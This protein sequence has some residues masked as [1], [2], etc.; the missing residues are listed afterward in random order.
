MPKILKLLTVVG[1]RPQFI[2]AKP[3]S[4]AIA[5]HNVGS[6]D[7]PI[8]EEIVHTGQHYDYAMSQAFFDELEIPEPVVNLEVGSGSHAEMTGAMLVR[9]E[10]QIQ[11]RQPDWVLVYGD[12]NSTLSAA[13]AATKL[14]VPV[15][16]VEAGMR[17][18]NRRMPEEA[19]RVLT[20]H[21]S[22]LLFCPSEVSRRNLAQEG[23]CE[24]VHVV[25]DVMYDAFLYYRAKAIPPDRVAGSFAL[26]T[27][28]RAENTD[29]PDRFRAILSAMADAPAPVVFPMHPRTRKFIQQ[30][31]IAVPEKVEVIEPVP[32]LSML[33]YL[34]R[35]AFVITDS[36]GLQ[37]DAFFARKRCIT[38]RSETEW[39]EL[40]DCGMN[41]LV[42][43]DPGALKAALCWALGPFETEWQPYGDG[44]AANLVVR[45]LEERAKDSRGRNSIGV[46]DCGPES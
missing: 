8:A 24:G 26:A 2:K 19:N 4:M 41:R 17:S 31:G 22:S 5:E 27:L 38:V 40:V 37:K 9:L 46:T 33:G 30:A 45:A 28:H 16:H 20:D 11:E 34:E 15:A 29:D 1:A 25:G 12:T 10:R 42:G 43:N 7:T 3:V 21:L 36:G 23:I 18:F 32:Y 14:N 13:L 39:T 6:P 35:C 44:H